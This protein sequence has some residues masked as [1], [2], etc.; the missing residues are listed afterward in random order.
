MNILLAVLVMDLV[1]LLMT[2]PVI[3]S[4]LWA[5]TKLLRIRFAVLQTT[6]KLTLVLAVTAFLLDLVNIYVLVYAQWSNLIKLIPLLGSLI[7]YCAFALILIWV[8]Y[9][10]THKKS[11]LLAVIYAVAYLLVVRVYWMYVEDLMALVGVNI[12]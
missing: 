10:D 2:L 8:M 4:A 6:I 1:K 11:I 12:I 5:G 3:F 9:R 7:L